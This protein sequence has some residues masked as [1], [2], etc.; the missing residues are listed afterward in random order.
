ML[1]CRDLAL[2]ASDYVDGNLSWWAR[3]NIR[4]HLF[5][6]EHCRRYVDQLRAVVGAVR[7]CSEPA[8]AC[9]EEHDHIVRRLLAAGPLSSE[10]PVSAPAAHHEVVIY[11]K[12]SCPYCHRAKALL[13][14]KGVK[15]REIRIDFSS[16][17]RKEMIA[18]AG[19]R[20]TVPQIFIDGEAIGG[21]DE[22]ASLDA[23]GE[24]DRRLGPP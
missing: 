23:Y 16:D 24:L 15:Y 14:R 3:V 1:T 18:R 9:G 7:L 11:T 21:S 2:R 8:A 19:G 13:N 4:A 10:R 6:C 12:L 22:L 20:T 17:K 5:L